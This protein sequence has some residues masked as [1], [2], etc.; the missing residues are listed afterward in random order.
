[1][2]QSLHSM[3]VPAPFSVACSRNWSKESKKHYCM[4]VCITVVAPSQGSGSTSAE[5]NADCKTLKNDPS[6]TFI[7]GNCLGQQSAAKRHARIPTSDH[8]GHREEQ[9]NSSFQLSMGA[10]SRKATHSLSPYRTFTPSQQAD[11]QTKQSG[12]KYNKRAAKGETGTES[13]AAFGD[14]SSARTN[15]TWHTSNILSG[16]DGL[17]QNTLQKEAERSKPSRNGSLSHGV[18]SQQDREYN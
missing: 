2:A 16:S 18:I 13:K 15:L 12:Y 17:E 14:K 4:L 10:T 7:D 6:A 1:M 11:N 5:N 9:E 3:Q 8:Q